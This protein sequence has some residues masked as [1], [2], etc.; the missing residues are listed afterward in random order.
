MIYGRGFQHSI[1]FSCITRNSRLLSS[2]SALSSVKS[3]GRRRADSGAQRARLD[4]P[5]GARRSFPLYRVSSRD[6]HAWAQEAAGRSRRETGEPKLAG[7]CGRKDMPR[8]V[9]A[10]E[11]APRS[12]AA[13]NHAARRTPRRPASAKH[14]GTFAARFR[15]LPYGQGKPR[16]IRLRC[17]P[18]SRRA[19]VEGGAGLNSRD[20]HAGDSLE[21]RAC[22][23]AYGRCD[24]TASGAHR[25][26]RHLGS[27]LTAG[28]RQRAS[29]SRRGGKLRRTRHPGKTGRGLI[30][31]PAASETR[32]EG[33]FTTRRQEEPGRGGY[34]RRKR[35]FGRSHADRDG[36]HRL[37]HPRCRSALRRHRGAW[38]LAVSTE[39]A[40]TGAGIARISLP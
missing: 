35:H 27:A 15:L 32:E 23:G 5:K 40:A 2:R 20:Q 10:F 28:Q 25:R 33:R 30:P 6:L 16:K 26:S 9:A 4:I 19:P 3:T 37:M 13:V 34:E 17:P 39:A 1:K 12:S 7:R 38:R 31:R 14:G 36:R 21:P 22:R 8:V 29:P 24:G 18:A 11:S